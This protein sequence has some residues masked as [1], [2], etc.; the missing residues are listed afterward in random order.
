VESEKLTLRAFV[1]G[2][3]WKKK[4]SFRK[5]G[6][7]DKMRLLNVWAVLLDRPLDS[8]TRDDIETILA[9]RRT[10]GGTASTLRRE[11]GVLRNAL[12]LAFKW[13]KID[14]LPI[15]GLPEPLAGYLHQSRLR[16][17]GQRG[18]D[19]RD[20]LLAALAKREAA[21]D[22]GD[23]RML[24]FAARLAWA[25]GMRR[26]EILGLR[27]SELG[28]A[29]ITIPGHRTKKGRTRVVRLNDD[30][31]AALAL[32]K[33]RNTAGEFFAGH[34]DDRGWPGK[35]YYKNC[36]RLYRAWLALCADAGINGRDLHLHDLRHS[37]AT[38][39]RM[40]AKAPLEVVR[41]ALGHKD[42]AST[43][44]YAHVGED[45]IADAVGKLSLSP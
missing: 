3:L 27:Q 11:W 18:D 35:S 6:T 28:P 5:D 8:I 22:D 1:E 42:L 41:D 25:T 37:F 36:G 2:D 4:L 33:V 20:R 17:V 15:A 7:S 32:W 31:R 29:V 34:Q 43:Q 30:A 45:E 16:Y 9:K 24:V 44:I 13:K 14:A 26:S 23:N 39:L 12:G 21:I 10:A 38:D 19:E 40:R